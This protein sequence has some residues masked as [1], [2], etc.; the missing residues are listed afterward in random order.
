MINFVRFYLFY[1][2]KVF[3]SFFLLITTLASL[4]ESLSI[5]AVLPIINIL[6]DLNAHEVN[7]YLK[8]L[9]QFNFTNF[10]INGVSA[11]LFIFINLNSS[12]INFINIHSFNLQLIESAK[13]ISYTFKSYLNKNIVFLNNN[14]S[15]S[16]KNLIRNV[17]DLLMVLFQFL[18]LIPK[19]IS[20]SFI[21]ILLIHNFKI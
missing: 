21:I 6:L 7:R 17:R 4:L 20:V 15:E 8:I 5:L 14:F 9:E 3:L 13:N 1:S 16:T 11:Y 18:T 10:I 12:L 2:N 19:L